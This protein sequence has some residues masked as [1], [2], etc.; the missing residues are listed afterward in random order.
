MR[1]G[2][3]HEPMLRRAAVVRTTAGPTTAAG[4]RSCGAAASTSHTVRYTDAVVGVHVIL[5]LKRSHCGW[6]VP[7]CIGPPRDLNPVGLACV[8]VL[9]AWSAFRSHCSQKAGGPQLS[10]FSLAC[11]LAP[12]GWFLHRLFTAIK[13][14]E[15]DWPSEATPTILRCIQEN[16]TKARGA[17]AD[18]GMYLNTPIP[19]GYTHL[20][21][22]LV[23]TYIVL[24]CIGLVPKLFWVR[25]SVWLGR[26][27]A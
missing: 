22:M 6:S 8:P 14:K 7:K 13:Q 2:S 1:S 21:Y 23:N 11:V 20:L 3:L 25:G 9:S 27:C 17:A 10:A 26:W 24:T 12:A 15:V 19:L 5:N 18:L 4:R 16:V